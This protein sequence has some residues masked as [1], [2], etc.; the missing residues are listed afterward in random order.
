MKWKESMN[1]TGA[2]LTVSG[3]FCVSFSAC[4]GLLK[5]EMIDLMF[6]EHKE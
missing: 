4:S 5:P 3:H 1:I 2:S 6:M